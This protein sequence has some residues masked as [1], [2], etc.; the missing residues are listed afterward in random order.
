MC[1]LSYAIGMARRWLLAGCFCLVALG[2]MAA[3]ATVQL[4]ILRSATV[5]YRHVVLKVVVGDVRPVEF[6]AATSRAV[7]PTTGALVQANVKLRESITLAPAAA[8][9]VRWRSMRVLRPGV[10]FVQL[11]AVVTGGV[12]DCPH[13]QRDCLD[14]WSNVRR[15][16]VA[17]SR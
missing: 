17:S 16:I 12:T 7:D 4:P 8:G 10:Y 11:K 15:V 3:P 9:V 1:G 14:H 5:R 2:G 13:F 6:I